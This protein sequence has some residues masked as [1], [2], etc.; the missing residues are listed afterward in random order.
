M[1][2]VHVVALL[3]TY[4]EERFIKG[5]LD[6]L[7]GEGISVYL[8][9]NEST[10]RTVEIAQGYL[11]KGLVGL[12]SLP[13]DGVYR[14]G[15]IL[16]RKE[17]LADSLDGD[18]F[19]HLDADEIRLAPRSGITL[20][21][22][23][24]EVEGQGYNA[25]TF[26]EFT[27]IP[28]E[29]E[30]DHDHEDFAQTMR[31]YYPYKTGMPHGLKAWKR[32]TTPPKRW[33]PDPRRRSNRAELA[34]SGGHRIRFRGMRIYDQSFPMRHYLFLSIPHAIEKYVERRFDEQELRSGWHQWRARITE[35]ALR[36]PAQA[37]LRAYEGDWSLD[38][39]NPRSE[40]YIAQWI[41]R[42]EPARRG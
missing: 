30:P 35:E 38:A 7:I 27:F 2:N 16:R 17:E 14:W 13:R 11:G 31:W 23:F 21:D 4:N 15:E 42:T 39:S 3:A 18:W 25:V 28:T 1:N 10:D 33:F 20:A 36:L 19:V 6:H 29:E 37:E 22:A 41:G 5:C 40:H 12:E 8:I 9:D 32:P 26:Q 24:A 34:W